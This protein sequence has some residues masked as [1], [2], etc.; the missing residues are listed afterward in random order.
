LGRSHTPDCL[1]RE[2]ASDKDLSRLPH[3]LLLAGGETPRVH[4]ALV[5]SRWILPRQAPLSERDRRPVPPLGP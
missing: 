1:V 3:L 2:F 4:R 5:K